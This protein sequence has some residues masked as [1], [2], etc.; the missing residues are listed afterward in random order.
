MIA[1]SIRLSILA[2]LAS[3]AL[4]ACT[5]QET[6]TNETISATRD[7]ESDSSTVVN[8]TT[9]TST[10]TSRSVGAPPPK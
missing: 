1:H 3:L 8:S 5:W 7:S 9:T 4:G 10:T 6:R 2:A